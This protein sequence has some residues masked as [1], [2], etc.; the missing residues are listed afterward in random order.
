MDSTTTTNQTTRNYPVAPADGDDDPRFTFGLLVD[1]KD[2]LEA[3]G[4]PEINGIDLAE[5]QLSLFRFLYR[6]QA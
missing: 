5:L 3:H 6:D 2:V 1:V 4:Y